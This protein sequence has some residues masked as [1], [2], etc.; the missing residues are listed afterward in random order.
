MKNSPL[1]TL[2]D[3]AP[4]FTV[5]QRD[6]EVIVS[7]IVGKFV[8]ACGGDKKL[9]RNMA[10][11]AK[12]IVA[13]SRGVG[14]QYLPTKAGLAMIGGYSE[15]QALVILA[16]TPVKASTAE[17]VDKLVTSYAKACERKAKLE[18]I[19]KRMGLDLAAS[20]VSREAQA[21]ATMASAMGIAQGLSA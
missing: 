10:R 4:K 3:T 14:A 1:A 2:Q 21:R 17:K 6:V 12:L 5:N 15:A 16:H 13:G 9:A 7:K 8:D 19:A 20:L 18:R 11:G